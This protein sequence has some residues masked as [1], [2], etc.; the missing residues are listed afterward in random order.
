MRFKT[1]PRNK[2]IFIFPQILVIFRP[3][4]VLPGAQSHINLPMWLVHN[5]QTCPAISGKEYP[6]PNTK[7]NTANIYYTLILA[8]GQ[9]SDSLYSF[10]CRQCTGWGQASPT[11]D[12]SMSPLFHF[13]LCTYHMFSPFHFPLLMDS[14]IGSYGHRSTAKVTF[15]CYTRMVYYQCMALEPPTLGL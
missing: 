8:K 15:H 6:Q 3:R 2:R 1:W 13:S 9:R 10:F 4:E 14:F 5:G 12:L 11:A 7:S